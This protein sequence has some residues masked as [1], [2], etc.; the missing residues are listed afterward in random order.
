MEYF[1]TSTIIT[2]IDIKKD[3]IEIKKIL[4]EK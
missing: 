1:D 3:L 2:I 4:K